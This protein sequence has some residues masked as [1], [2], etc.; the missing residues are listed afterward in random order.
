MMDYAIVTELPYNPLLMMCC[1]TI[2]G[3]SNKAS[4]LNPDN[5]KNSGEV[6]HFPL[7]YAMLVVG[8]ITGCKNKL[9]ILCSVEEW[10][11]LNIYSF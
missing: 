7:S 10:I 9:G 8:N 6:F 11:Y 2:N 1:L 5:K 4:G 3:G